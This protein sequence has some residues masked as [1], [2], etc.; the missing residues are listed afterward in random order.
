MKPPIFIIECHTG[1]HTYIVSTDEE[2]LDIENN[3]IVDTLYRWCSA[4]GPLELE[5]VCDMLGAFC[6]L[7]TEYEVN[8]ILNEPRFSLDGAA[9]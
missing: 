1:G 8:K 5:D 2:S 6:E 3:K 7:R 4:D 9:E